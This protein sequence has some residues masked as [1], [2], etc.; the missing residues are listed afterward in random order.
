MS[1]IDASN[2]ERDLAAVLAAGAGLAEIQKSPLP[3]GKPFVLVPP[4]YTV[5]PVTDIFTEP[6]RARG[7][8]KLRDSAS[9]TSYFNR[10]KRVESLI[11]ASLNPA[12]ILG[13]IDD[14]EESKDKPALNDGA[15]WREYRVEFAVPPSREW[16]TWTDKDR[17][18]LDQLEFAALIEDNL[19][20]IV[21]PDGSTML[22]VALN[23]E[24]SKDASFVSAARLS[25]GSTTFV[26]KEDV[27]ATAGNKITMPT[28]M[29]L[30]IP[31]F[32]NG[33]PYAI[34]ARIKYRVNGGQLHIWYE[35]VRPHKVLE[36]AFRAIW[37]QIEGET[38]T[39]ILLGSPE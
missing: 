15:N 18:K 22:T 39:K 10:Q 26:W 16:K 14:H 8:V 31:V 28:V 36:A 1:K 9:F 20:D 3:D 7:T 32:E 29:V 30:S 12:R 5:A 27:N 21:T 25:D 11:Y 35:L 37:S 33:E 6:A 23:F 19:P 38:G 13:V 24:A 34:E 2:G 17:T 4:G